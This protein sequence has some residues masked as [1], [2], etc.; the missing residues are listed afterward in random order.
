MTARWLERAFA[1]GAAVLVPLSLRFFSVPNVLAFCDRWPVVVAPAQA[2]PRAIARRVHRWLARGRGPW[3]SS[4][5]TRS[6]VLY[7]ML[8]QHGYHPRFVVGVAGVEQQ[9]HAHAWVTL[10]G[11]PVADVPDVIASYTRLVAHG[12]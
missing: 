2:T 5:L 9:F 12:A 7:V 1:L 6:L 10:A 11:V 8:R 3:A 4:C